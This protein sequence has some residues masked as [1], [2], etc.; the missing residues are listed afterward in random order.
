M[1]II[2]ASG[3]AVEVLQCLPAQEWATLVFYDDVT[4]GEM[5]KLLNYFTVLRTPEAAQAHLA[6]DPRFILGL[7]GPQLRERLA[8]RFRGWG[9]RLT[10]VV[11]ASATLGPFAELGEGLNV[12]QYA[13]ISPTARL[14]EGVLLNA[15]AAV[16]HDAHVGPY[17]EISPG[18]RVLGR[19]QVGAGCQIGAHAIILPDL[20]LGDGVRV[21]AGAVVTKSVP[22]G[23]TVAGVPARR[24]G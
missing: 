18:A 2:G 24:L 22:A 19:C 11:A 20:V 15:G 5:G 1:I 14:G 12:M 8:V 16:H 9:G 23:A 7:G 6:R 17:C 3:H 21:G 4:P 13:L 10:S